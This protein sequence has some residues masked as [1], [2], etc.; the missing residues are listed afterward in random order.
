MKKVLNYFLNKKWILS[1]VM[2]FL[3]EEKKEKIQIE[4]LRNEF[5]FFGYNTSHL[6]DAEIKE[7]VANFSNTIGSFGATIDEAEKALRVLSNCT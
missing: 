7:G 6:S 4:I 1:I 2:R 3:S 5:V